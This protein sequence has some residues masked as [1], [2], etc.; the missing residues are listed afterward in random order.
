MLSKIYPYFD[1]T[2]FQDSSDHE[3][4]QSHSQQD[5]Q[6]DLERAILLSLKVF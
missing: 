4:P 2:L 1:K 6:Y 5:Y 3:L